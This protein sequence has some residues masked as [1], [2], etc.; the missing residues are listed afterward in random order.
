[1]KSKKDMP[2]KMK[3][4][5]PSKPYMVGEMSMPGEKIKAKVKMAAKVKMGA[6]KMASKM[7]GKSC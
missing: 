2:M 1:M 7:K 6:K 4:P 3:G 5:A